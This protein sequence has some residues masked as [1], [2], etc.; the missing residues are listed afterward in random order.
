MAR[1]VGPEDAGRRGRGCCGGWHG[2]SC[3]GPGDAAGDVPRWVAEGTFECSCPHDECV[4]PPGRDDL[5][6]CS[7]RVFLVLRWSKATGVASAW[8]PVRRW[9]RAVVRSTAPLALP[10]ADVDHPMRTPPAGQGERRTASGGPG[11]ASSRS[12]P[13]FGARRHRRAI[14]GLEAGPSL[15]REAPVQASTH[16]GRATTRAGGRTEARRH[17]PSRR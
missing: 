9:V 15:R 14:S 6:V 1:S 11:K 16:G 13:E 7:R 17:G 10:R 4:R 5:L 12:R 3:C 8:S 2:G